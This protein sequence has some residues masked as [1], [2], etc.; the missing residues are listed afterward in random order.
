MIRQRSC[1]IEVLFSR[2]EEAMTIDPDALVQTLQQLSEA[3]RASIGG[4]WASHLF[5][6]NPQGD[7]TL[8]GMPGTIPL[9]ARLDSWL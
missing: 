8:R 1:S 6:L 9:S 4:A 7:R 3:T 2:K 5:V